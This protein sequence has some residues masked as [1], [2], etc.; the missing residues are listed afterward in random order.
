MGRQGEND[1][2]VVSGMRGVCM[3]LLATNRIP[4]EIDPTSYFR[5]PG[6]S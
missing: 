1:Q 4:L 5:Q 3:A 2:V 6:A